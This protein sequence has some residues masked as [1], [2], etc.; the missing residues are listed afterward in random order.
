M[1]HIQHH[2]SHTQQLLV[3]IGL[4]GA[5]LGLVLGLFGLLQR[6]AQAAATTYFVAPGGNDTNSCT[7]PTT[8]CA[9][10]QA[11]LNKASSGDTINVAGGTYTS[12]TDHVAT[13]YKS[14]TLL[15][16][17]NPNFLQR[18]PDSYPTILDGQRHGSV[19]VIQGAAPPLP[20]ITPTLD[21]FTIT[22]GDGA[23]ALGCRA[24]YAPHDC[25]GGIFSAD[26]APRLLNNVI[27]D[28]YISAGGYHS[29]GGGMHL[30]GRAASPTVTHLIQGVVISDNV[31][32]NN[33]AAIA[34]GSAITGYGGGIS[35]YYISATIESNTI[36]NNI[37]SDKRNVGYGGG[38][39]LDH[40]PATISNNDFR[41][42]IANLDGRVGGGG[43][44]RVL[45]SSQVVVHSNSFFNNIG[46]FNSTYQ[47]DGG[48]FFGESG[49]W[50]LT[51]NE[52]ISNAA[53]TSAPRGFGGG[54]QL[55][56]VSLLTV[57]HNTFTGNTASKAS[58]DVGVIGFGG[59]LNLRGCWG[60]CAI[61]NNLIQNNAASD[62][63]AGFGGGL[64]LR[65]DCPS[66][67]SQ[68]YGLVTVDGNIILDNSATR[69]STG[70]SWG[71]GVRIDHVRYLTMTNNVIAGNFAQQY[72]G[73]IYARNDNFP[74]DADCTSSL[75]SEIVLAHNSIAENNT[76][77]TDDA[78]VGV[79][80]AGK[81]SVS[82]TNN[83]V[84]SH[85]YAIFQDN[86]LPVASPA[87]TANRTLFYGD[88]VSHTF[89]G[90]T[91]LNPLEGPP[92]FAAPDAGDYHLRLDSAAVGAGLATFVDHDFEG[93]VRASTNPIDLGADELVPKIKVSPDSVSVTLRVGDGITQDLSIGNIGE[94]PLT[95]GDLAA[96]PPVG[97]LAMDGPTNGTVGV[98]GAASH[99]T[100]LLTNTGLA[101]G[102]HTTTLRLPSNDP[103]T[104][105]FSIPV[106]LTS[107]APAISV[108]PAFLSVTLGYSKTTAKV[109]TLNNTG[110]LTLTWEA[111]ATVS[112][113]G[114]SPVSGVIG[115]GGPPT[116][117]TLTFSSTGLGYGPHTTTLRLRS[118][119]PATPVATVPITLTVDPSIIGAEP[120]SFTVALGQREQ[121]TR[122]LTISNLGYLPLTWQLTQTPTV[123]W[124]HIKPTGGPLARDRFVSVLLTFNES[125]ERIGVYSTTLGIY[126][127][128]ADEPAIEIPVVLSITTE[129]VYLPLIR[130]D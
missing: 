118:N 79:Y 5:L 42:N 27:R 65:L 112:W 56:H 64:G 70:E 113:L 71:G 37:A 92:A 18:D 114:V 7:T 32:E 110:S 125:Q 99:V 105:V 26:A 61:R 126:N 66:H 1:K 10:V 103:G 36:Q 50:S 89:G 23:G 4:A 24:S 28:N 87:V 111:E 21:G 130:R 108:A 44:I 40:S 81:A 6:T 35:L 29:Y 100:L 128:G 102:P 55:E 47:G 11:A 86:T 95:W 80:I 33:V 15:G 3:A 22:N 34:G 58:S 25:G 72:G 31:I 97:W 19:V 115:S 107:Q 17:W 48:A 129:T 109:L 76:G 120:L 122:T 94:N 88:T 69:N 73:G 59:A 49:G 119:D 96:E 91:N 62:Y 84:V 117:T 121:V 67:I 106:T 83:I 14:V 98:G 54:F 104:P 46:G 123:P 39:S 53:T 93:D 60:A 45:Q 13:I 124:L 74:D 12:A 51:N 82:M 41:N 52:V 116:T 85:S 63:A 78:R 75:P 8:S 38:I 101:D 57:E 77:L 30:Q 90:V 127:Q 16:G 2:K 9:T 20:P 43:G 68:H